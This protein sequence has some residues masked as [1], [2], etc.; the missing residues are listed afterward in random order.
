MS[1]ASVPSAPACRRT[2]LWLAGCAAAGAGLRWGTLPPPD[3]T[4]EEEW[5]PPGAVVVAEYSEPDVPALTPDNWP[6]LP[7]SQRLARLAAHLPQLT[8]EDLERLVPLVVAEE[9]LTDSDPFASW[10]SWRAALGMLFTRWVELDAQGMVAALEGPALRYRMEARQMAVDV[11]V[12]RHGTAALEVIGKKWP[13]IAHDAATT[14]LEEQ[15]H[16]AEALL[17][18]LKLTGEPVLN[19]IEDLLP[20]LG[21]ER[22]WQFALALP[23]GEDLSY[24]LVNLARADFALTLRMAK[25][26]PPGA[27]REA[28]LGPLLQDMARDSELVPPELHGR[29]KVEFEALPPG[30]LRASLVEEYVSML[31]ATDGNAA[32]A[33][34]RALPP[35]AER[36]P[37]LKAAERALHYEGRYDE[38]AKL[39]TEAWLGGTEHWASKGYLPWYRSQ[40]SSFDAWQKE[41]RTAAA[42][43]LRTVPDANL[44]SLMSLCLPYED[45]VAAGLLPDAASQV[46]FFATKATGLP[47]FGTLAVSSAAAEAS[48][49]LP[50]DLLPLVRLEAAGQSGVPDEA[51]QEFRTEDRR[52]L[53]EAAVKVRTYGDPQKALDFFEAMSPEER[54]LGAWHA[55]GAAWV[56]KDEQ[57]A[58]EWMRAL[59]PG[60]ER[61]AAATAL[62]EHLTKSGPGRDGEAA[63]AW[64]ADMSGAVER[65]YYIENAA[66]AWAMED[67]AAARA[68]VAAAPLEEAER[69]AL[70]RELPEGG[71]R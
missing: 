12:T 20:A 11:W 66:W 21:P 7:P 62:V 61:D 45:A 44:R 65:A 33:W 56:Q 26:L 19:Y 6:A 2:A 47:A 38:A 36:G 24:A 17:P 32:A 31:A 59:P 51:W 4:M 43:W 8:A 60:P 3:K 37:A 22:Y 13:G 52:H 41:D 9:S 5:L 58:S 70:L 27:Q 71:A 50:P 34:A 15:P 54:S 30:T 18:W 10:N 29:F 57:A 25:A 1:S 16:Q 68:A 14:L 39:F 53:A 23:N 40:F 67:A 55:V 46:S 42:Q 35:G 28:T 64:A 49:Y 69:A 63:F 48:A